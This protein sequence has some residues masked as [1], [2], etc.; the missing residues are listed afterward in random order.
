MPYINLLFIEFVS[1]MLA[2]FV[3]VYLAVSILMG[4]YASRKV[5]SSSDFMFAGRKLPLLLSST[6]LFATWFGSETILGASSVFLKEGV[7]GVIED[8][9]GSAVCLFLIGV[10]FSRK[11]YRAN[12]LTF[13]D[14]FR[15]KYG[16][17]I[18][19]LSSVMMLLSFFGWVAGQL[20]ALGIIVHLLMGVEISTSILICMVAVVAYTI[21][22]G[23]WAVAI[24]DFIQTIVI[25]SGL[26]ALFVELY[27]K[28]G[29]M[30]A[31]ISQLP[32]DFFKFFPEPKAS[33]W[34]WY[35]TAW[36]TIGLGSIPSQDVLQRVLSSKSESTAVYSSLL[37]SLMYFTVALLP[38][39]IVAMARVLYPDILR[40]D[41]QLL[42][43]YM[44]IQ[45]SGLTIQVLFFGAMVS[46]VLSTA[47]GAILA[48]A[49]VIA[50]NILKPRLSGTISDKGFLWLLR[51]GVVFMAIVSTI[52]AISRSDIYMLVSESS[53]VGLVSIFVPLVCALWIPRVSAS[54]ITSSMCGGLL[55]WGVF[56]W[57]APE[58]FVPPALAGLC[59]SI[60][61]IPLTMS[62]ERLYR[63]RM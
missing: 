32:S 55:I 15:E 5:N 28:T 2:F 27:L 61:A 18:E 54:A 9:F 31:T 45:H 36:I 6:A 30:D 17:R 50:E 1:R 14:L 29:G 11:I 44:V 40:G 43:P 21:V 37:G 34:M 4:L 63:F 47:S 23:M 52:L 51:I 22:G 57:F 3:A 49:T 13:C 56:N 16:R 7:L 58:G 38:L 46:A 33:D 60:I 62:L 53:V 59:A 20:V 39:G 19:M 12:I 10:F 26:L 25:I 35:F 42:I 8:P 24:T 41:S 48:G